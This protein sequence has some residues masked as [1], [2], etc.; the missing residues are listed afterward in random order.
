MT[1]R[2]PRRLLV[3]LLGFTAVSTLGVTTGSSV[4]QEQP[5]RHDVT[6][7]SR[8]YE[9]S[10]ARIE[11]RQD[12]VLRVTLVAEDIPHSFT[13]DE[14]RIAKRAVPGRPL[15]FEFR[16]DKPG[17]FTYYCN[18]TLDDGCREMR[19]ELVVVAR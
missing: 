12:D 8:K 10:P 14:Y 9:F 7:N 16:A 19:G 13:I 6:I 2:T 15:T 11:I 5:S 4:F 1:D 17:S 18:L 3:L